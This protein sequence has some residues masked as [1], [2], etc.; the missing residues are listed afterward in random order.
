MVS[1]PARL[2]VIDTQSLLDWLVFRDRSCDGW[3]ELL[4]A[5]GWQWIFT[6]PM[7]AEFDFIAARGFGPRWPVDGPA[8]AAAWARHGRCVEPPAALGAGMRLTCTDPDDQKFIDLAVA[9]R[10]DALVTRD[11]ALL[12]LARRAAERHGMRV[13]RPQ[14]WSR[15]AAGEAAQSPA[16]ARQSA[17]PKSWRPSSV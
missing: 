1:P 15:L 14:E 11:K 16:S 2:V 17:M 10:A 9:A 3:D 13:C 4:Q 6:S 12:K 5:Q 7:K 8:V